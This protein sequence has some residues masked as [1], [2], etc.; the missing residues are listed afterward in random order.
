MANLKTLLTLILLIFPS[1]AIAQYSREYVELTTKADS[2]FMVGEYEASSK[3]FGK[4]LEMKDFIQPIHL[5]NG[6]CA[7]ALADDMET[8]FSRLYTKL[9]REKDWYSDNI[10]NDDDLIS[11]HDDSRWQILIDSLNLRKHRIEA[12]FDKPLRRRLQMIMKTDQEVRVAF[13]AAH[14]RQPHDSIAEA[15]ALHEMQRV[16]KLNQEQ[17]CKILDSRGFVGSDKVGDAVGTF[18]AVIQHSDVN[19]QKKYLPLFQEAAQKGDIAKEG[20]AMMEDRIN[21]FEGKPQRYGSQIEEDEHGNPRLYKLLD[22]S[23]VDEW[24]SEMGMEPLKDYL[25]KMRIYR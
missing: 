4:A 10:A 13:L 2:L 5:Y 19:I 14:N 22:E 3:T 11:L 1:W 6:A 23:K 9:E 24:R 18:W 12:N 25:R 16:D 21:M 15:E 8:A 17:I 20:V 7:A